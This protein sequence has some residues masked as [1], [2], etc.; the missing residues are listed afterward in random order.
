MLVNLQTMQSTRLATC[1]QFCST[2][3][4]VPGSEA[5]F[6]SAGVDGRATLFDLREPPDRRHVAVDL[7]EIGGCTGLAFDPTS[8]GRHFA[9]GNDDP[10][11]RVYDLRTLRFN[12]PDTSPVAH[13]YAPIR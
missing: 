12:A 4:F 11:V 1:A 3:A 2:L 7:S 6:L 5:C 10:L 13:Q 8:D 9:L